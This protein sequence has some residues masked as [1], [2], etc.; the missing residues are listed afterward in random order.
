MKRQK[1]LAKM[2]VDEILTEAITRET[3]M[4][5]FYATAVCE[6][7]PDACNLVSRFIIQCDERIRDIEGLRTELENLRDLTGAIAD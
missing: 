3:E 7:G 6:V 2:S 4:K 1:A 5:N